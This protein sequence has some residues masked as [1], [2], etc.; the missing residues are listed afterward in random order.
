MKFI[1]V[2]EPTKDMG[3]SEAVVLLTGDGPTELRIV[4]ALSKRMNGSKSGKCLYSLKGP[5][6]P[7]RTDLSSLEQ[8]KILWSKN[9]LKKILWICD[10]EHVKTEN[11]HESIMR[12]LTKYGI[13]VQTENKWLDSGLFRLWLA[14]RE[15]MLWVALS[16]LKQKIEENIADLIMSRYGDKV[17]PDKNRIKDYLKRRGI[18]LDDLIL[19]TNEQVIEQSFPGLMNVLKSIHRDCLNS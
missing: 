15:A 3:N 12:E 18:K 14:D 11:W 17:E 7:T 16:G 4:K 6:S 5:I 13:T 10:K 8:I 1:E 9:P 2:Q 19:E